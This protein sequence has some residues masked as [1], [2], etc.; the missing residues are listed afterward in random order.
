M[1]VFG[2]DFNEST[3][4][5]AGYCPVTSVP[6]TF[7]IRFFDGNKKLQEYTFEPQDNVASFFGAASKQPFDRVSIEEVTGTVDDE[8]LGKMYFK[9]ESDS[10]CQAYTP[11]QVIFTPNVD[12]RKQNWSNVNG[13]GTPQ[14]D[15]GK[16]VWQVRDA[17]TSNGNNAVIF[18]NLTTTELN[19]FFTKGGKLTAEIKNISASAPTS[20]AGALLASYLEIAR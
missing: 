12:P 5:R 18:K 16:L 9:R 11:T 13:I 3:T 14:I 6:S 15:A 7:S 2:F 1:N 10:L 4:C 8:A 20:S 17:G 19:D